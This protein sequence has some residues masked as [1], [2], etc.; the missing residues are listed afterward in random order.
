MALA[1]VGLEVL[2]AEGGECDDVV[3]D[4]VAVASVS[5][6]SVDGSGVWVRLA[7]GVKVLKSGKSLLLLVLMLLW[8]GFGVD[9]RLVRKVE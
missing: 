7:V 6:S 1:L 9:R 4:D 2:P 5:S 3:A 8:L